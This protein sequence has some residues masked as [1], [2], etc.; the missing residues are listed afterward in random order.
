MSPL[1]GVCCCLANMCWN[2]CVFSNK[3]EKHRCYLVYVTS[4]FKYWFSEC[5]ET[6]SLHLR[7]GHKDDAG[8]RVMLRLRS[9]VK[10][11]TVS[12]SSKKKKHQLKVNSR[13]LLSL[14]ETSVHTAMTSVHT[15]THFTQCNRKHNGQDRTWHLT[16]RSSTFFTEQSE[17]PVYFSGT[18]TR[19]GNFVRFQGVHYCIRIMQMQHELLLSPF[20][21]RWGLNEPSCKGIRQCVNG[22]SLNSKVI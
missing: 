22:K 14:R 6:C 11:C 21:N 16:A 17:R 18:C 19:R 2:T 20:Q 9:K 1:R 5:A 8:K 10:I 3:K 7:Y 4:A 15:W 12:P 13:F